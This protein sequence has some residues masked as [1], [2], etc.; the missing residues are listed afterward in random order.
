MKIDTTRAL[1]VV[2]MTLVRSL[3]ETALCSWFCLLVLLAIPRPARGHGRSYCA[4]LAPPR[5]RLSKAVFVV[6][7]HLSQLHTCRQP[8]QL[9]AGRGPLEAEPVHAINTA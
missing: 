3:E 9:Q 8:H 4:D 1:G 5:L 6:P 2:E 7:A